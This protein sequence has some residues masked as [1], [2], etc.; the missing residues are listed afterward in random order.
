MKPEYEGGFLITQIHHLSGRIFSKKLQEY[1]IEIGAGQGRVIFAL[2]Q[3]DGI[4]ISEL[5]TRTSLGKSTVTELLDRLSGNELVIRERNPK[6]R[7][8]ILVKLTDKAK[9][10]QERYGLVSDEM[11]SLFYQGF[12]T[13]EIKEFEGYLKRL[14]VNLREIEV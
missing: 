13:E 12:R 3:N 2:W 5:S 14:L 6:D 8:S 1:Q 9:A 11:T 7:R 4:T 10:M